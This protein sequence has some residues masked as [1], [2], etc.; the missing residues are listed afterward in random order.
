MIGQNFNY[1]SNYVSYV[2]YVIKRGI[3]N[4]NYVT[5][6]GLRSYVVPFIDFGYAN[7]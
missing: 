7:E 3:N 4:V 6:L 5:P 1:V 2:N